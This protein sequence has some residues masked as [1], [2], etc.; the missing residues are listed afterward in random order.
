MG[1][2]LKEPGILRDEAQKPS[3]AGFESQTSPLF[4]SIPQTWRVWAR[5][6]HRLRLETW[7]ATLLDAAGSLSILGAQAIYMSQPLL[8]R[9]IPDNHLSD[10]AGLLEEPERVRSFTDFLREGDHQ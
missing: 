3:G 8:N 7:V 4:N 6:L 10:L 9:A 2:M 1:S 5:E